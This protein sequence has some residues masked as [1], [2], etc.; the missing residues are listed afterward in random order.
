VFR[1]PLPRLSF[2]KTHHDTSAPTGA[3]VFS[4][5]C[6]SGDARDAEGGLGVLFA[7]DADTTAAFPFSNVRDTRDMRPPR[8]APRAGN[9]HLRVDKRK[10]PHR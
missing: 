10:S 8:A 1:S 4:F 6:R 7:G 3:E 2:L 5:P 9:R